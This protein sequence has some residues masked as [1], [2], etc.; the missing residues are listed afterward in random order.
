[1][2]TVSTSLSESITVGSFG[3]YRPL[4]PKTEIP[5]LNTDEGLDQIV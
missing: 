1:M 5:G 3:G 4:G 2:Y